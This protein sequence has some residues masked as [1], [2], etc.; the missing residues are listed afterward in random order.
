MNLLQSAI[1]WL[2]DTFNLLWPMALASFAGATAA[3]GYQNV[4]A[5]AD[6]ARRNVEERDMIIALMRVQEQEM[7]RAVQNVFKPW[8]EGRK[9]LS[10]IPPG[11]NLRLPVLDDTRLIRA[12]QSSPDLL[13][14]LIVWQHQL[15][16][17]GTLCRR[18][19]R[20]EAAMFDLEGQGQAQH[21]LLEKQ[22]KQITEVI[23]E[24]LTQGAQHCSLL[25]ESIKK[26]EVL[27][28]FTP[29]PA[30]VEIL[31]WAFV[32][33]AAILSGIFFFSEWAVGD[34]A[35]VELGVDL[36]T[37]AIMLFAATLYASLAF[38]CAS[39]VFLV[40][41]VV[42]KENTA[43]TYFAALA[44][45]MQPLLYLLWMQASNAT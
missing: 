32:A 36:Q 26:D 29:P 30:G 40:R 14:T 17:I 35:L 23:G 34:K 1:H 33:L 16:E 7:S 4:K 28:R 27:R 8:A 20:L 15:A 22:L 42:K 18:R 39:M 9:K 12:F 2:V 41:A 3:F 45:G 10:I 19:A 44:L 31:P 37:L 5:R 21:E 24:Y 25:I 6:H 13:N 43:A 11:W 38:C